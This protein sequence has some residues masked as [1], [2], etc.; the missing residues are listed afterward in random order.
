MMHTLN[1]LLTQYCQLFGYS[2]C[3][4]L[5]ALDIFLLTTIGMF[6]VLA[7]ATVLKRIVTGISH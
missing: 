2:S 7:L 4:N 5:T 6:V 1:N 3:R